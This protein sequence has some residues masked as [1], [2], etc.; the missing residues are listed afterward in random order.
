M[1]KVIIES[2]FK[3]DYGRNKAYLLLCITDSLERGEAP[4]ASHL[5]Y[6]QMLDDNNP[7]DRVLG[8]KAGLIWADTADLIAI[9]TDLGISS[10]MRQG[11][12]YHHANGKI[13]EKR[14]LK[15]REKM[16]EK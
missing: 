7:D 1:K 6:T 5:F 15:G 9:Y 11:I 4:F 12:D 14:S 10:G 16:W 2:P 8:I 3:G 13:I